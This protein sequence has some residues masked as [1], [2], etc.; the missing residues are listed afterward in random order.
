[1]I[2]QSFQYM[3][4]DF[5][6]LCQR[7][8]TWMETVI[9]CFTTF[10]IWW[11]LFST[12]EGVCRWWWLVASWHLS[13]FW[14]PFV[15]NSFSQQNYIFLQTTGLPVLNI[16]MKYIIIIIHGLIA[17]EAMYFHK[18]QLEMVWNRHILTAPLPNVVACAIF[19][20]KGVGKGLPGNG[21]QHLQAMC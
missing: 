4:K 17:L 9:E 3:S 19:A 14:G 21:A 18:S 15:L 7:V 8:L 2:E 13:H 6:I 11:I 20:L 12:L 10:G 5:S 1:M 16:S